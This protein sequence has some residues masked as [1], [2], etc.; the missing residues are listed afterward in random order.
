MLNS[1][2]LFIILRN[3]T[4]LYRTP[5]LPRGETP[6]TPPRDPSLCELSFV[7]ARC[8]LASRCGLARFFEKVSF[9]LR[10]KG[11]GALENV[12]FTRFFKG[13]SPWCPLAPPGAP[14]Q[15]LAAPGG[16]CL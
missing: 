15:P 1:A 11:G 12:T 10:F 2:E 16:R 6:T 13:F 9:F 3:F 4:E 7:V 5:R 8:I 14:W